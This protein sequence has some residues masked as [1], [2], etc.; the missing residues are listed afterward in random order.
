MPEQDFIE[1]MISWDYNPKRKAWQNKT[2][3]S[4]IPE[5][6]NETRN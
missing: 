5:N 6:E 3:G 4:A 2:L 1:S